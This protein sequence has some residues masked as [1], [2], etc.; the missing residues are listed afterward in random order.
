MFFTKI[1]IVFFV[2]YVYISRT[3]VKK[4]KAWSITKYSFSDLF[5]TLWLQYIQ[6]DLFASL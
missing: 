6:Q 3:P 1:L 2:F 5:D 4:N